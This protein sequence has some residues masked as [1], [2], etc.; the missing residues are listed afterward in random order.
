MNYQFLIS[1]LKDYNNDISVYLSYIASHQHAIAYSTIFWP[2]FECYCDSILLEPFS[3]EKYKDFLV[4]NNGDKSCVEKIINHRHIKEIWGNPDLSA[5]VE[6]LTHLGNLLKEMWQCKL[7]ENFP[8]RKMI[9]H[10]YKGGTHA[11]LLDFQITFW[12]ER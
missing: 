11:D 1:E 9:V 3:T 2:Q 6:Q 8:N 12:S 5:T 4:A 10:F 7:K